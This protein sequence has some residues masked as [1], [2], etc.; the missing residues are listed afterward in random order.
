VAWSSDDDNVAT[1]S[2]IGLVSGAAEGT[3]TITASSEGQTGTADITVSAP[4]AAGVDECSS[5][6]PAW[7]WCD[8]FETDRTGA[9]FEYNDHGGT[10]VRATN[11]GL[12]DSFGM[13]APW[14]SIGQE[15]GGWL[16]LAFGRTPLPYFRPVDAGTMDYRDIYWRLFVKYQTGWIGG[17]GF[18]LTRAYGL[19]NAAWAQSL[20]AHVWSGPAHPNVLLIDPASGTDADGNLQTTRW[21]DF[22]NFRWLPP[23]VASQTPI[24]DSSH[25]GRWYCVE[26]RVR[27]NDPQQSNGVFQLW[28]D[29]QLE[30]QRSDLN[31]VGYFADYGINGINIENFW[32]GGAPQIQQRYFDQFVVST[33]RIGC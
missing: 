7:I 3:A 4:L 30:A 17:G 32:N 2:G 1:V 20:A 21:N 11:V 9:Y 23:F 13:L 25:V 10:F 5:P 28:I 22:D 27:L 26:A 19:A 16:S 14:T 33:E 18:K 12:D 24:F 31:W 29:D 8:D 6:Q 15:S